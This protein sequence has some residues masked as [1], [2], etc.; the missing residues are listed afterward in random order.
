MK[1][2]IKGIMV[3]LCLAVAVAFA[4]GVQTTNVQA[5]KKVTYKLKKGT[6]TIKGKGNMPKKIKVKKSKVKKIV[7][8]KGVKNISNN[9][10]KNFKK[11]K[12]I[13]IAKTVKSIGVNAFEKTAIT[14][15]TIPTKATKLGTGFINNCKKLDVVTL[16]GNF[17]IVNKSGKAQSTKGNTKGTNLDTVIFNTALD[18]NAAAYFRTYNFQTA[19]SDPKFKTFDGVIYT[20]DGSGVV[21]VPSGRDTVVF[22]EGCTVFNTNAV[23]YRSS[24]H[25]SYV[26]NELVRVTLPSTLAKVDASAYPDAGGEENRGNLDIIMDKTSLE[27]PQIVKIKNTFNMSADTLIKKL[28]TRVAKNGAF[29]VG[30]EKYLIEGDGAQTSSV[31]SGITTICEEA[32][33]NSIGTTKVVLPASVTTIDKKAFEFS[34][35][36]EINLDNVKSLGV[37]AFKGTNL[38]KVTLPASITAIPDKLFYDCENLTEVT[39]NGDLKS[40]GSYAFNNARINIGD[41]LAAN[42]KLETISESAFQNVG[43]SNLTIPANIKTVGAYA[44]SE[45][46]NTKFVLIKGNTS[47]FDMLAFGICNGVTYQFEQGVSQAWVTPDHDYYKSGK[48]MKFYANWDKV[49]EV[50]GYEIWLAKDKSLKK[51]VKKYTAK[52]NAKSASATLTKKKAK[53][54]KYFGIRAYKT[55]NGKKVYSKW[56]I[57][58]L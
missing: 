15:L 38:E 11:V 6:L 55:V 32:Y 4:A 21:R 53:G 19:A 50:N 33:Y 23:L 36:S 41:F 13:T 2:L 10:F 22:R 25:S 51:G 56:N 27:M 58:K 57:Q 40:V 30:D 45:S 7:I 9:A 31:P 34:Y 43:W 20:K 5:K 39:C 44:F 49:S 24:K 47:G 28:P 12:K 26:C 17:T 16:P 8:K 48:K 1:N 35:L 42:T 37:A 52:Y 14:K 29:L 46:N 3:A 18:Y 54:L